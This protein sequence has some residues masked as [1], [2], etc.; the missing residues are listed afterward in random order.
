LNEKALEIYDFVSIFFNKLKLFLRKQ[1]K[2]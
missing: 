2:E 1:K